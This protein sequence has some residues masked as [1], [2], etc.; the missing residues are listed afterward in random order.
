M[1]KYILFIL[2]SF[3]SIRPTQSKNIPLYSNT[4]DRD[5]LNKEFIARTF[6]N[7]TFNNLEDAI[8]N[9]KRVKE[10]HLYNYNTI[11]EELS[12]FIYLEELEIAYCKGEK[13][14]KKV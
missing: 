1:L 7:K 5:S 9:F 11:P 8:T 13:S 14:L 10:I 3:F 6:N 12:N 2:I 4:E